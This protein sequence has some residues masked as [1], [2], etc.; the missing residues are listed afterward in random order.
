ML[1]S[2]R[3]STQVPLDPSQEIPLSQ[4]I[5]CMCVSSFST[6]TMASNRRG[7]IFDQLESIVILFIVRVQDICINYNAGNIG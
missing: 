1:S 2:I 4:L 5:I 3:L 7:L 6:K